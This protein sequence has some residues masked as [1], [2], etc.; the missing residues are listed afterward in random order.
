MAILEVSHDSHAKYIYV[1]CIYQLHSAQWMLKYFIKKK[2]SLK[3]SKIN[4]VSCP[5]LLPSRNTFVRRGGGMGQH[6]T[7]QFVLKT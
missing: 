2:K 7:E 4:I 1:H 6:T 3:G 5:S